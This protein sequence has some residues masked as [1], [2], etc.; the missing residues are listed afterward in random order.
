LTAYIGTDNYCA[1][2][3]NVDYSLDG[4]TWTNLSKNEIAEAGK[5]AELKAEIPAELQGKSYTLRI[6]GDAAGERV[7]N[8]VLDP[9][10]DLTFE[11]VFV[12]DIRL[13]GDASAS[14]IDNVT[15]DKAVRNANVPI[16]DLMGR[17]VLKAEAGKL[18][19]QGGV[20]F[21]QQ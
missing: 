1:K 9:E 14:A 7:Y 15:A 20:K 12:A 2:V 8:D 4:T 18:Y 19:I 10:T 17:R 21:I 3:I 5:W 13:L 6:Q 16:F 11:F